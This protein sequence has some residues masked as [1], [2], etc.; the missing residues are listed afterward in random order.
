[1]ARN[2]IVL[3]GFSQGGA[4]SYTAALRMTADQPL[5]GTFLSCFP[6]SV[7]LPSL[8]LSIQTFMRLKTSPPAPLPYADTV[9][10]R[11][12]AVT[13]HTGLCPRMPPRPAR[14]AR[15]D[16]CTALGHVSPCH[17]PQRCVEVPQRSA[18]ARWHGHT[19]LF[20][21]EE[22]VRGR[23]PSAALVPASGFRHSGSRYRL[24]A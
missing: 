1:M 6:S 23:G 4:I 19:V 3:A 22:Y 24:M 14:L 16:A 2:R 18:G 13:L 10:C 17:A 20:P 11:M 9:P 21:G 5:A 12:G 8:E 7:L 15:R